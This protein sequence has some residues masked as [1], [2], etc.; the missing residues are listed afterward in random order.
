MLT[1]EKQ[2]LKRHT[3][4]NY[5]ELHNCLEYKQAVQIGNFIY[6]SNDVGCNKKKMKP[7]GNI[8]SPFISSLIE[9]VKWLIE[10]TA[11][12]LYTHTFTS[13]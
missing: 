12:A 4:L 2:Y 10:T 9:T 6:V 11:V 1:K 13:V 8:L 7:P 3:S 5:K